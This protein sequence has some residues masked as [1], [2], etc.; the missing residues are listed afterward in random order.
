MAVPAGEGVRSPLLRKA[1]PVLAILLGL[2]ISI[3]MNSFFPLLR[4][5]ETAA[6][7][8]RRS[9]EHQRQVIADDALENEVRYLAT[10]AGGKWAVYRYLGLVAPG[11]QAGRLVE[12]APTAPSPLTQPQRMR[13]WILAT[14]EYGAQLMRGL[15][16][17]ALCYAGWRPLDEPPGQSN[18]AP[19]KLSKKPASGI[20]GSAEA[21]AGVGSS[22]A[23][24]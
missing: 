19:G 1:L 6:D 23:P 12:S 17:T 13:K 5:G 18:E 11:Q 9:H 10:R 24:P 15:G 21:A 4:G 14:E 3:D 16:E 22:P 2:S 20:A 7:I 8:V